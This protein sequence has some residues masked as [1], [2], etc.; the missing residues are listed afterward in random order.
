MVYDIPDNSH[1]AVVAFNSEAKTVASLKLIEPGELDGRRKLGSALPRNPSSVQESNKCI[2][3]GIKKAVEALEENPGDSFTDGATIILVTSGPG[4]STN[5]QMEEMENIISTRKLKL[6][7]VLYPVSE[8]PGIS[9]LTTSHGL[10][11]L[12]QA[13]SGGRSFSVMDE[14]VGNDSKVSM[15]VALMDALL[16]T[17]RLSGFSNTPGQ[18]ILVHS[19]SYPGGITSTSTGTFALDESL[20]SAARFSI[21]FYDL[22]HVGNTV[23]LKTPSGHTLFPEQEEDNDVNMLYVNIENAEVSNIKIYLHYQRKNKKNIRISFKNFIC[24]MSLKLI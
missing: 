7:L 21:F 11:R 12:T 8:R 24:N 14:G 18:P 6:M 5:Q 1:V 22:N 13:S 4:T 15:L 3:C 19:M 16:S 10:G 20:G 2:L 23:K 17:I 9:P